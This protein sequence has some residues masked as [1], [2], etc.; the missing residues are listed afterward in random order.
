MDDICNELMAPRNVF[1]IFVMFFSLIT[2]STISSNGYCDFGDLTVAIFDH[3][4]GPVK[5]LEAAGG[6]SFTFSI[7]YLVINLFDKLSS[8]TIIIRPYLKLVYLCGSVFCALLCFV[9]FC[10]SVS[11]E[12]IKQCPAKNKSGAKSS[13]VFVFFTCCTWMF[14]VFVDV[15]AIRKGAYDL[16]DYTGAA[17]PPPMEEFDE[18]DYG[19][20]E[21]DEDQPPYSAM[22]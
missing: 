6:L 11:Y 4:D 21:E 13:I 1:Y 15:R 2:F 9:A 3:R 22:D 14:L 10:F 8:Y 20:D 5:M 7:I 19:Y 17:D 16:H 12:I 18:P